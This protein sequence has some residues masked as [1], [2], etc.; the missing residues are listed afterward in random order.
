MNNVVAKA[1]RQSVQQNEI[2]TINFNR[3]NYDSEIPT[4]LLVACD[5]SVENGEVTEYWG[6]D[7]D[8]NEWRVHIRHATAKESQPHDLT[9]EEEQIAKADYDVYS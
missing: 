2:V 8:G 6:T 5:D 4:D 9:E 7:D 3:V 1:I